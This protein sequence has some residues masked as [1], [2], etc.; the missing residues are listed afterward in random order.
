MCVY[1]CVSVWKSP[2][3]EPKSIDRSPSNSISKV[4]MQ[5]SR[6]VFLVFALPLKLTVVHK[7]IFKILILSKK[8][9]T[10]LI[11]FCEFIVHSKPNNVTLSAFPGKIPETRKMVF[12]SLSVA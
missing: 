9:V 12:N 10:I 4:L 11:K 2:I 8:A 7:K 5:I 1:V 6:A 3:V